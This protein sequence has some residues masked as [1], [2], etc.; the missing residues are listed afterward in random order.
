MA[1]G[2]AV[3]SIAHAHLPRLAAKPRP[4]DQMPN[5]S[6]SQF[7]GH[8]PPQRSATAPRRPRHQ[9]ASLEPLNAGGAHG[10]SLEDQ[11][12]PKPPKEHARCAIPLPSSTKDR[13]YF[14][15]RQTEH[16]PDLHGRPK[17][18][19]SGGPPPRQEKSK[20]P[21]LTSGPPTK[22]QPCAVRG[23]K[24]HEHAPASKKDLRSTGPRLGS[25][26]CVPELK[27]AQ[28]APFP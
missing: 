22:P 2:C 14:A 3:Q 28:L 19:H 23:R 13:P 24:P 11:G 16:A 18:P 7:Q 10:S 12:T 25:S 26:D 9:P 20:S 15:P 4:R 21:D 1:Q 27:Y 8:R 17:P 5:A 6:A